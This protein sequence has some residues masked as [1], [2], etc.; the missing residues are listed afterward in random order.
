M[1]E[2]HSI[3]HLPHARQAA[4]AFTRDR[5]YR[6]LVAYAI[7]ALLAFIALTIWVK[8]NPIPP[9]DLQ[10]T[11][12]LQAGR[13]PTLDAFMYFVGYPG[14]YPQVIPLNAFVILILY[15]CRAKWESITLLVLGPVVGIV[16]TLLRYTIDRPRPSPTMVWVAQEIEHLHYSFPSGHVLGFVAIFGFLWYVCW[17]RVKPSWHRTL[18]L[19]AYAALIALVAISRVYVGEHWSSDVL[20]GFLIGSALLA[21]IIL[22]YEWGYRRLYPRLAPH[23]P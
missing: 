5:D 2:T 7:L 15:L 20:G 23:L 10:L 4:A 3:H 8:Q 18:L 22:F 1:Q 14:L 9:V 11:R 16:G 19:S 21:V 6:G 17:A 12:A 13:N